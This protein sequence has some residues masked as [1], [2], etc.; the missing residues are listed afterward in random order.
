MRVLDSLPRPIAIRAVTCLVVGAALWP[1]ESLEAQVRGRRGRQT[2]PVVAAE[3]VSGSLTRSANGLSLGIAVE[4]P[5]GHHGYI[6]RGDDGF[7]IPFTFSFPGLEE[8][9]VVVEMTAAPTGVRDDKVRAQV[10]RGSPKPPGALFGAPRHHD[11]CHAGAIS[12]NAP[13][14]R[15]RGS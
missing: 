1:V 11:R 12:D 8:T 4:V 9:G 7:L 15:G 2:H 6:D 13:P 3:V 14:Y 5:A 10:L